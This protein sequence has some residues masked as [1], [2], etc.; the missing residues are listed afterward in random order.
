ML[1]GRASFYLSAV[2][3]Y[4][5]DDGMSF[6]RQGPG[7]PDFFPSDIMLDEWD[8]PAARWCC[9]GYSVAYIVPGE[10]DLFYTLFSNVPFEG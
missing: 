6:G 3:E 9:H 7:D 4:C 8:I 1:L 5:S 2:L 10:E